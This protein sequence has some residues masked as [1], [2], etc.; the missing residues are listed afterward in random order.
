MGRCTSP[1]TAFQPIAGGP[2]K[3]TEKPDHREI[4]IR[5]GQCIDCLLERSRQWAVR[6]VHEAQLHRQ[7][8]FVT[9]TYSD[10]NLPE[11]GTLQKHDLQSFFKRLRYHSGPFRYYACGEYGER[12]NRA[13][14]HACIFGL[15][16]KDKVHFRQIGEHTLYTSER[17]TNIWGLG[18]CSIGNLSFETAAYTARYVTKKLSKG[19]A[20]Y[21]RVDQNTGEVIPVQQPYAVMSLRPAIAKEWITRF[22]SDIYNADKDSIIMRGKRMKP[23][24]YYDRIFDQINPMKMEAIKQRRL[25]DSETDSDYTNRARATIARAR[26]HC[27]TQV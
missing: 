25:M 5:C 13:H 1:L 20:R 10:E 22:H 21:V 18:N 9:L 7:N 3:F 26:V 11:F 8:C 27:K 17:L 23:T 16:F 19:Q 2:L 24:R 12:T 14:Y 15:N 4:K 6:C